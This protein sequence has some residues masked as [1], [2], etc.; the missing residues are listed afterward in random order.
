MTPRIE[1]KPGV[2]RFVPMHVK[3]MLPPLVATTAPMKRSVSFTA[4]VL[5]SD[6]AQ[7][8]RQHL[9]LARFPPIAARHPR[10]EKRSVTDYFAQTSREFLIVFHV[11]SRFQSFHFD[12]GKSHFW[13]P[14]RSSICGPTSR[15]CKCSRVNSIFD[16]T[17]FHTFSRV[18]HKPTERED[19]SREYLHTLTKSVRSACTLTYT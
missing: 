1:K 16:E 3:T 6:T 4:M 8:G 12:D 17:K 14:C 2:V 10:S 5:H 15:K 7:L 18:P 19:A 9:L 13:S 11:G